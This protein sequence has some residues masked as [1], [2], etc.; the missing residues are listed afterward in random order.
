[1]YELNDD[2]DEL[3]RRAAKDYPLDTKT[4]DWNK[5]QTAMQQAA[6]SNLNDIPVSGKKSKRRFLWLLLLL[7]PF[8]WIGYNYFEYLNGDNSNKKEL[9]QVEH[10]GKS[11]TAIPPSA[12]SPSED[13]A[14]LAQGLSRT[15]FGNSRP[16]PN[17]YLAGDYSKSRNR[18]APGRSP[19]PGREPDRDLTLKSTDSYNNTH[20]NT[21]EIKEE[22][23]TKK[24]NTESFPSSEPI[25]PETKKEEENAENHPAKAEGEKKAVISADP[26]TT[27]KAKRK[28]SQVKGF[29]IGVAGGPDLSN[30][31]LQAIKNIGLNGGIVIG[32]QLNKR[33]SVESG[34]T[35]SKKYYYSSG[36]YFSTKNIYLPPNT[37][38]KN[39]DGDCNMLELPVNLRYN[40][41]IHNASSW[42]AL[43][44][45]SSYFMKKENYDY[46]YSYTNGQTT[47]RYRSYDNS[48]THW[49][50]V[51]NLGVTYSHNLG[52]TGSLRVEPY[53]KV[54]VKGIGIGI[55]PIMSTGVNIGFTKKIF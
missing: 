34:L 25:I 55:M 46:E 40:F 10:P 16:V 21:K 27:K 30:V 7:P 37:K 43:A 22:L 36:E 3:F 29:Y 31:K 8:L 44:G 51:I 41:K 4:A 12:I 54:P 42:S 19:A 28:N 2:M 39:V 33:F 20:P 38:I 26:I 50:S 35:W 14:Q 15:R 18:K 17:R 32:Y 23:N 53:V 9:V 49:F 13:P 1:M 11:V 45:F 5:L 47:N 6:N 48:S 24:L 52:R